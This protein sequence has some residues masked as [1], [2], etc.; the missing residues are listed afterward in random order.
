M[1]IGLGAAG[2]A[3]SYRS[4]TE[5]G[6]T[7]ATS[8]GAMTCTGPAGQPGERPAARPA[9]RSPGTPSSCGPR[10]SAWPRAAS[11]DMVMDP[12]V[13]AAVLVS[14]RGRAAVAAGATGTVIRLLRQA[15]GW[16]QQELADRSGYSQ[17]TIS[18]VERGVSRAARDTAV[19]TDL[20]DA[21]GVSPAVLGVA[22]ASDRRPI[23]DNVDRRELLGGAV[24]LAVMALLPQ[25]VATPGRIDAAD[26]AQCW[27]ALRRLEELDAHQGG[28][29][30]CQVAE[31]MV[32]RLQ[33]ALRR[34]SYLPPLSGASCRASRPPPWT[35]PGGFPTTRAG[36][37]GRAGGGSRRAISR[38]CCGARCP[39][40]RSGRDGA[41]SQRCR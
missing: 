26:A 38:T 2:I 23:L 20:A 4:G 36:R 32:Q 29:V 15:H 39:S 14:P 22:G 33:D 5:G 8:P 18:R 1:L 9:P 6:A 31:G 30:V 7:R 24:G 35:R 34:G 11:C 21:L 41:A 28:A 12:S 13:V 19:R 17:A 25:S 10:M 40:V 16:N 27:T 3:P 37:I